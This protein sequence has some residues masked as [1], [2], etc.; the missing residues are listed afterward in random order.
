MGVCTASLS[1]SLCSSD[2][3]FIG[4]EPFAG[5]GAAR[6]LSARSRS[7]LCNALSRPVGFEDAAKVEGRFRSGSLP[8]LVDGKAEC[9]CVDAIEYYVL[10]E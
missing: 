8:Y 6:S 5:G 9:D 1:S 4:F 3:V 2:S 10:N 7:C